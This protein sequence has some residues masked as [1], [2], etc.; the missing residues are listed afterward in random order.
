VINHC[1]K[2]RIKQE[3]ANLQ[4]FTAKMKLL[5]RRMGSIHDNVVGLLLKVNLMTRRYDNK[6]D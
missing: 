5:M 1:D 4:R 3:Q 2:L 6:R